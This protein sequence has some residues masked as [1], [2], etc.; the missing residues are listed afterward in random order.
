[1]WQRKDLNEVLPS[2]FLGENT[3]LNIN[4]NINAYFILKLQNIS[5]NPGDKH[6]NVQTE[7]HSLK[8]V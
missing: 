2:Y 6:N 4:Q 8:Q 1:M 3:R 5:L 7:Q